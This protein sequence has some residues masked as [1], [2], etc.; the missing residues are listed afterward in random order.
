MKILVGRKRVLDCNVRIQVTPDGSGVVTD[1]E[2]P[3]LLA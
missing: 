1:Q 3:D 2:Q